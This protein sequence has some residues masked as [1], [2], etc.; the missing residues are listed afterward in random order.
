MDRTKRDILLLE[1]IV[2]H[3]EEIAETPALQA[4]CF[5]ILSEIKPKSK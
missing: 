5:E 1:K 3:C 2:K 4:R